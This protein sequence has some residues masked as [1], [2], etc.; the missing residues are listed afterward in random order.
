MLVSKA[1]A[2]S[3]CGSPAHRA[4][5]NTRRPATRPT[6]IPRRSSVRVINGWPGARK[7]GEMASGVEKPGNPAAMN[8][9]N[10]FL[11]RTDEIDQKQHQQ[12]TEQSPRQ[13]LAQR[14][15]RYGYRL[16]D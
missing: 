12:A 10:G 13:E 5:A 4:N 6:N 9:G 15:N 8:K 16:V 2:L 1:I 7:A 11:F 3:T 14:N